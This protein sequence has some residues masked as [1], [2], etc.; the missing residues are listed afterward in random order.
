MNARDIALVALLAALAIMLNVVEALFFPSP[1]PG[2][3]LGIANIVTVMA[4]FFFKPRIVFGIVFLRTLVASLLI[5]NFLSAGYF[6]SLS[7][8]MLSAVVI[9][10][11]HRK[12]KD[13]S[14]TF[15]S[16]IGAIGHNIGQMIAAYLFINVGF[17]YY[18]PYLIIFAVPAGYFTGMVAT[19]VLNAGVTNFA[20]F[21][22]K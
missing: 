7:G 1:V 13:F 22:P 9:Y 5:G 20:M 17:L 18:L 21:E 11:L 10:G 19:K 15:L 2:L 14:P 16:V 8:S 6:L 4:V 3:K 12:N